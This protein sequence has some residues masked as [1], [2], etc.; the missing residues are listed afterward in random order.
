[1]LISVLPLVL[2]EAAP[3]QFIEF[4]VMLRS[5]SLEFAPKPSR[6]PE[7]HWRAGADGSFLTS[8]SICCHHIAYMEAPEHTL[9]FLLS[10]DGRL[11]WYAEGYFVKFE[12][13]RVAP[14][15]ERPHGCVTP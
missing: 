3:Q 12:I 5:K 10:F 15:K 11:H 14:S 6:N 1:M 8:M 2:L 7:I 13:K 4:E 9:E